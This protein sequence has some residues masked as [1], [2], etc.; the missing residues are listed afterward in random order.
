MNSLPPINSTT[1]NIT[2]NSMDL[3]PSS[4]PSSIAILG[5]G[6][7]GLTAA[8]YLSILLPS[9]PITIYESSPHLGGFLSTIT[10]TLPSGE[11]IQF[12]TGPRT[13]RP[14]TLESLVLLD[15]IQRLE[16][17]SSL[18]TT[19]SKAPEAKNRFIF[20]PDRLNKLPSSLWGLIPAFFSLPVLK[21][22][23]VAILKEP[24]RKR[25]SL[26][27]ED[28]SV[29]SF[30]RRRFGGGIATNLV[31][32]VLHGI[33]AGDVERLSIK[34][35]FPSLWRKEGQ[36]GSVVRGFMRCGEP[37]TTPDQELVDGVGEEA[38]EL[39]K[40]MKG[41]SVLSFK[42]GIEV[43]VKSLE[44]E[45]EERE[46]VTIKRREE[47]RGVGYDFV[48]MKVTTS[49]GEEQYS[50]V[51]S[52]LPARILGS[53]L[54]LPN[55]GLS[56]IPTVTVLVVN[57]Y[58]STPDLVPKGFGYLVPT[59]VP[60]SNNPHQL[61]GCIFDPILPSEPTGTK[62]TLMFGGHYWDTRTKFPTEAEAGQMARET[63]NLHLGILEEPSLVH[64]TLQRECIPQYT[65]G[66]EQRLHAIRGDLL[67][68]FDGR[69]AVAGA[70][71]RGIGVGSCIRWAWATA[72]AMA[73]AGK[74]TGLETV[75]CDTAGWGG[76]V[77]V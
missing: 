55:D 32:A 26:D 38:K 47:V 51:I 17:T 63:V 5:G 22:A 27:I 68:R 29:A 23:L 45:L 54:Q 3:L 12:E 2:L 62:L 60:F 35:V 67:D 9:V 74:A 6:I 52:T 21:G 71:Y 56:Q 31:G 20:Y 50:H 59:S 76:A 70:S 39:K 49:Q 36:R 40:R 53:F 72:R 73:R 75:G 46:M 30:F 66:H 48:H 61:L 65:L 25:R 18:I 77:R 41:V 42:G 16:L 1:T 10:L 19:P 58:F 69:L 8:F 14:G 57:M 34:S 64:V 33:F 24:F 13:L 11:D 4:T 44:R 28:E 43:L 7:S 37:L 15:V